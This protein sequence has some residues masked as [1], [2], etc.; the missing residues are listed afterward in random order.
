MFFNY[1]ALPRT[2]ED[3]DHMLDVELPEK[4]GGDND[5]LDV[6]RKEKTFFLRGFVHRSHNK[7]FSIPNFHIIFEILGLRDRTS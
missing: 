5:P 2:W 1:G 4:V 6:L 7:H 3:P